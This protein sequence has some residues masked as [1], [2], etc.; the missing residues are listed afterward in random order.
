MFLKKIILKSSNQF[1]SKVHR[2]VVTKLFV[3]C[4]QWLK[5]ET[6][7]IIIGSRKIRSV[8]EAGNLNIRIWLLEIRKSSETTSF[9]KI[10]RLPSSYLRPHAKSEEAAAAAAE[11]KGGNGTNDARMFFRARTWRGLFSAGWLLLPCCQ[12]ELLPLQHTRTHIHSGRVFCL[13]Q[14]EGLLM[15]RA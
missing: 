11:A 15:K 1:G 7:F 5:P 2:Y 6:V 13:R 9:G 14:H 3:Y 12:A 4:S 8:S 10:S